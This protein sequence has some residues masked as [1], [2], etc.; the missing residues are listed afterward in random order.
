MAVQNYRMPQGWDVWCH[1][2]G[3]SS[4][5][6]LA[7]EGR[8]CQPAVPAAHQPHPQLP[9]TR[10]EAGLKIKQNHLEAL[11]PIKQKQIYVHR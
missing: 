10:D 11:T 9:L 8:L 3:K 5:Q 4:G 2:K 7:G 1:V 6:W